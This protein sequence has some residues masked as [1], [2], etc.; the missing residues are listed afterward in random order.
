[1]AH[2][3]RSIERCIGNLTSAALISGL[4]MLLPDV[5]VQRIL[6]EV[7]DLWSDHGSTVRHHEERTQESVRT[8]LTGRLRW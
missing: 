1:M 8:V 6:S 7:Q 4:Y 5:G 2:L 3:S